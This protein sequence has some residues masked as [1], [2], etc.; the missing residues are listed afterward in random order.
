VFRARQLPQVKRLTYTL[1]QADDDDFLDTTIEFADGTQYKLDAAPPAPAAADELREPGP[2]ELA[3]RER[4]LA[5]G[6]V[7]EP[8]KRE[9]RFGDDYDRSWPRR[10]SR[11]GGDHRNL[12]NDRLGKLEPAAHGAADAAHPPPRRGGA[13]PTSILRSGAGAHSDVPPHLALGGHVPPPTSGRR[14]SI[15]SPRTTSHAPLHPVGRRESAHEPPARPLAWGGAGQRRPSSTAHAGPGVGAAPGAQDRQL[16]PHLAARAAATAQAPLSPPRGAR[17][18]SVPA[19]SAV[20]PTSPTRPSASSKQ[21]QPLVAP[22]VAD[23]PSSADAAPAPAA[24]AAAPP[25]AAPEAVAFPQPSIEE[26]HAREMHAAAERARKRREEEEQKRLEQTERARK[27]AQELEEKMKA[28]EEAKA[29]EKREKEE[30]PRPPPKERRPSVAAAQPAPSVAPADKATS[31]R[32]AAKPLPSQAAAASAAAAGRAPAG[33]SSRSQAR[34]HPSVPAAAPLPAAEPTS[35]LPRPSASSSAPAAQ[36]QPAQPAAWRRPSA[37]AAAPPAGSA[38]A[39]VRQLPPHLAAQAEAKAVAAAAAAAAAPP[40]PPP[41]EAVPPPSAETAKPTTPPPPP[42]LAL[43]SPPTSPSQDRKRQDPAAA[44]KHGYKLP[45]V[46]QFDDL[47]SRIKGVMAQPSEADDAPASSSKDEAGPADASAAKGEAVAAAEA[48]DAV[49]VPV[50]VP[51]VKLPPRT[52][53]SKAAARA[54][55]AAAAAAHALAQQQQPVVSLPPPTEPRGRGRARADAPRLARQAA[56][57]PAFESREPVLPYH[58]SRIARSQSPPPAWRQYTIR[59]AAQPPRRPVAARVLKNFTNPGFPKPLYPFS[60]EPVL[61]DVNPRRLNRDDMLLPKKYDKH[62]MPIYVV[63]LPKRRFS[64]RSSAAE[65]KVEP[66]IVVSISHVALVR[67]VAPEPAAAAPL[68]A[69]FEPAQP[70]AAGHVVDAGFAP[71][72]GKSRGDGRASEASAAWRRDG[73]EGAV[74]AA[75]FALGGANG[76]EAKFTGALNGE[77]IEGTP[78][79]VTTAPGRDANGL[80]KVRPLFSRPFSSAASRRDSS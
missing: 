36:Q 59:L 27:K 1:L 56:P 48:T 25:S 28:A 41:V 26:L 22:P 73:G 2:R 62:G 58:S 74:G 18:P 75:P 69:A 44:V 3:L 76:Q 11:S 34:E 12:F 61:K 52:R 21:A 37:S 40:P 24:D 15:T 47:M 31:W 17:R 77:K 67:Q 63:A 7:V 14:P 13:E 32:A 5:P 38:R 43:L 64:A 49:A 35:I 30:A 39:P 54:A 72:S 50:E 46:S 80:S 8:P 29:K 51:T 65:P 33:A 16:P 78:R 79:K 4:P 10:P 53:A 23:T 66:E 68:A 55:A 19:A 6:E 45:A 71:F 42:S 70:V 9:E 60:W 57:I 20:L